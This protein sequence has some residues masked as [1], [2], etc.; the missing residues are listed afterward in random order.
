MPFTSSI[1]QKTHHL[2]LQELIRST[3]KVT[4]GEGCCCSSRSQG[5]PE[6]LSVWWRISRMWFDQ[7]MGLLQI[8]ILCLSAQDLQVLTHHIKLF[9][10][11][12]A[13][14]RKSG[15][16]VLFV[17]LLKIFEIFLLRTLLHT[18]IKS[19]Q[20]RKKMRESMTER[21]RQILVGKMAKNCLTFSSDENLPFFYFS[22]LLSFWTW[23]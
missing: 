17:F 2:H 6:K 12:L 4:L 20:V 7:N 11:V 10:R 14:Q 15:N 9:W 13:P 16:F 5:V 8:C 19:V 1:D 23:N 3:S 21:E 18:A 22:N